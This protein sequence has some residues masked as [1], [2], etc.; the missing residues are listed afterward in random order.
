ME[1]I[2]L[3]RLT[4]DRLRRVLKAWVWHDNAGRPHMILGL[5][6][7]RLPSSRSGPLHAH[8]HRLP[9]HLWVV[10]CPTLGGLHHEYQPVEKA[11]LQ[12]EWTRTS[13]AHNVATKR[14]VIPGI[15]KNGLV[16]PQ[17]DTPLPD[18]AH[19]DILI[20]PGDVTPALQA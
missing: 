17:N 4:D 11:T 15:V 20:G 1:P 19:V 6:I 18:G 14:V 7:P 3:Q 16:V 5:G 12:N 10:A 9:E 2:A 13:E 8:Q